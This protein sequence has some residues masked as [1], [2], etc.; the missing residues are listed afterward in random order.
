[1]ALDP[2]HVGSGANRLGRVDNPILREPGTNLPKI[3]ATTI[4]GAL[5]SYVTL[6]YS[7]RLMRSGED[8]PAKYCAEDAS[9]RHCRQV[10]CPVCVLF[11]FPQ[12]D[13]IRSGFSSMAQFFDA[14]LM[15]FPV[16]TMAGPVW[17]TSVSALRELIDA[18]VLDADSLRISIASED[19]GLQT[20]V[21]D[22]KLNLGWLLLPVAENTSP[23]TEKGAEILGGLGV[24]GEVLDHLV[25]TSDKL[26]SHVV[27][28]NLEVRT[29][30]AIDPV[31]GTSK[32]GALF[33]YEAIPRSAL[34]WFP[35]I[36][37]DPRNFRINGDRIEH[38]MDWVVENVERGLS[39]YEYLGVGGMT[40][41]GM[42]RLRVLNTGR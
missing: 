5:R 40:S 39:Y 25:L 12:S 28:S 27:N 2:V 6:Y 36:Y 18:G 24:P 32:K 30:T 15:F 19:N 33:T 14:R 16:H 17:A 9:L 37:K 31:T 1:M 26:Y 7:D 22:G 8:R 35:V 11:G 21:Q 3:P 23:L 4:S 29:S 13:P 41:R 34:F 10:D 38:D 20:G 42:G